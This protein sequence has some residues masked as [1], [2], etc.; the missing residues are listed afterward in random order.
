MTRIFTLE[1]A[2]ILKI[3]ALI[4]I[5]NCLI[6][7]AAAR[8]SS[9]SYGPQNFTILHTNDE[10]SHLIP[11]SSVLDYHPEKFDSSVGGMQRLAALVQEKEKNREDWA[12]EVLLVSAGDFMAGSPFSWLALEGR[13]PELKL[14]QEIGYD[15]IT[16]GNHEFDYGPEGLADYLQTAGYPRAHDKTAL[17]ASN[18][19]IPPGHRL[20]DLEIKQT[21]IKEVSPELTLGFMGLLGE[22]AE[23]VNP[24]TEPMEFADRADTARAMRNRLEAEGADVIIAV[25]HSGLEE[26]IELA[27]NV[28][29]LDLIIGGHSHSK[30]SEPREINN[31]KI[32]QA[33]EHLKYLGVLDF[34]YYPE[35]D[36]LALKNR[37][38]GQAYLQKIDDSIDSDPDMAARV[39]E[40]T[41]LLKSYTAETTEGR[42]E[43][44]FAV[45]FTMDFAFSDENLY[46]DTPFGNFFTD[47]LRLGAEDILGGEVDFAFQAN[48]LIRGG[49]N[50][51]TMPWAENQISYYELAASSSLFSGEDGRPGYPLV[52]AYLTGREV[53]RILEISSFL[54]EYMGVRQFF[55][56]SGLR[57]T[58]DRRRATL[59]RLPHFDIPVPTGRSVLTAEKYTGTGTQLA[60]PDAYETLTG[61]NDELYRVVTDFYILEYLP[62]INKYLPF[63]SVR[64]KNEDG[65]PLENME[66]AIVYRNN[67]EIKVWEVLWHYADMQVDE[68]SEEYRTAQ[69][70]ISRVQSFSLL[71]MP[72]PFL[73]IVFL[74]LLGLFGYGLYY[75]IT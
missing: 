13:A 56:V 24:R 26:D 8:A 6:N 58:Y 10:H 74:F 27:Q 38:R 3:T 44:L 59:F 49:L 5:L 57:Y 34:T 68:L 4:L 12:Q 60:D 54:S 39:G 41:D 22:N 21:K 67:Q 62:E 42:Y 61:D 16:L 50:P 11:H 70:R 66:D 36:S 53:M 14:M 28:E 2:L 20:A 63:L 37:E 18:L 64:P 45:P 33:D 72:G 30:L 40:K 15:L 43:D 32:V 17:I 47:A 1:I 7:P 9:D 46:S 69:D 31:T 65:T 23:L 73:I 52:E 19:Q 48:G 75:L 35:T 29:R 51:G 25:T 71:A 55:Q